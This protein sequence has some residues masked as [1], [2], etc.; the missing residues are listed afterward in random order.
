VIAQQYQWAI[1]REFFQTVN[2]YS[3]EYQKRNGLAENVFLGGTAQAIEGTGRP[4]VF[5]DNSLLRAVTLYF[6]THVF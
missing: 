2:A 5:R 6:V 4:K 3:P 1:F